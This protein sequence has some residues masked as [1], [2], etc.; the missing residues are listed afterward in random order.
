[1]S[2]PERPIARN[3]AAR[4]CL[5]SDMAQPNAKDIM[6]S[7]ERA[8]TDRRNWESHWQDVADLIRPSREFTTTNTPGGQ[9]RR[10]I[11]D[12]SATK[13]SRRAA[14]AVYSLLVNPS[15]KWFAMATED[16][17][18]NERRDNRIW[19]KRAT[20]H[21]LGIFNSPSSGFATAVD[22]TIYDLVTFNTGVLMN[23]MVDGRLRYISRPLSEIYI[24]CDVD[25]RVVAVFRRF[26][27]RAHEIWAKRGRWIM[28]DKMLE[29][30]RSQRK[31]AMNDDVSVLHYV[32]RR[33]ERDPTLDDGPNKAWASIYLD[34]DAK[35]VMN[36]SGFDRNPYKVARWSKEAGETYGR[37]PGIDALPSI[38]GVNVMKKTVLEA[39]EKAVH[40]PL[41]V[42]ANGIDGPIHT[43][44]NSLIYYRMGMGG[45]RTGPIIPLQA[46]DPRIGEELLNVERANI[47]EMFYL[48]LIQLPELDRMTATEVIERVQQKLGVMAPVL[49]RITAELLGPIIADAT[50]VEIKSGRLDPPPDDITRSGLTI[51]YLGPLAVAQRASE[52]TNVLRLFNAAAPLGPDAMQTINTDKTVR[53]LAGYYNTD[54]D[55]LYSEEDAE[56]RRQAD[57][58]MMQAVEGS[59]AAKNVGSAIKDVASA[60]Q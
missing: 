52:A 59:E 6:R 54:P 3:S 27:M 60:N 31:D 10:R 38:K 45:N 36:V 2:G 20:D 12:D 11:Y 47:A 14:S 22:E 41:Q 46:T 28:S 33:D 1:M 25:G 21:L 49:A 43:G 18:A 48:D 9:R 15:T 57:N 17:R 55:L 19:M 40:P 8:Q 16:H 7:F 42:P 30:S 26:T 5:G 58:A 4:R 44:P 51:E 53:K 24:V 56:A 35:H 23:P 50:M 39:G 13:F 29:R 32:H 37:G 34:I